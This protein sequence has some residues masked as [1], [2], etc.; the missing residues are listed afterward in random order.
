MKLNTAILKFL[1][2]TG[3]LM[4]I[5]PGETCGQAVPGKDENIPFLVTFGKNGETSW[6]DD[7][8][9]SIFFFTIPKDFN[10]QFYIKVFD[11]DCG[12][13][14]DELQGF[15]DTR[16][17]FS[18]YGGKG[19]DPDKNEQS[20]G[21][22]DG[23]NFKA[24]NLLASK[25]FAND[26]KYDNSYYVFGPFNPSEGD[27]NEKWKSYIFKI[28]SEGISGD[29]GNLVRY[30][31]SR[32]PK[33]NLAIEG[34]NAFTYEYTFRMW[35][36]TKSMAHIYPYVDTGI[37]SIRQRNFDW[38]DDGTILVVSTYKQGISVPIS[39]E[40]DWAESKIPIE[41]Q[42]VGK[43]LDFQF[44]KKQ[45]ALVKNNNVVILLQNQRGDALQFFSSPIGGVPVYQPVMTIR[46]K[47]K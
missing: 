41:Q 1:I 10:R 28:V 13:E 32:D 11:P 22:K 3:F 6:G 37:V 42:E 20:K 47:T 40:D 33:N 14:N 45:E 18:V 19:V 44:H 31:L 25:V 23:D 16:T 27:Y 5:K 39:N 4:A 2:F 17:M 12:G 26:A 30:F 15:W 9:V 29:D 46:K 34:A 43:S 24:G 36:D 38:D 7:D 21:L 35:N 8:F